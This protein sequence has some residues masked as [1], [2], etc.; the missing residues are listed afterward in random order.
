MTALG[1]LHLH[2]SH[3]YC[4]HCG[5]PGFPADEQIGLSSFLT[6]QACRM[7]TL[8]GI[9]QPFR[10][11]QRVLQELCGWSV[12]AET[13]RQVCH[14][15][16]LRARRH[17]PQRTEA[18]HAFE[19]STDPDREIHID[20]GKVNTPEGW[21]DVKVAVF[22]SRPRGA[23]GN[24]EDYEQ[25]QLP[26]P[27]LCSVVAEVETAQD[28]GLRCAEEARRLG[29][30]ASGSTLSVLGDGAE[31]IWK[32]S[33]EHFEGACEV[34]DVYHGVEKLSEWGREVFGGGTEELGLWLDSARGKLLGDGYWGVCE[35]LV[36]PVEM[37]EQARPSCYE[38]T[39]CV[40]SY[41][42]EHQQRL[43]YAARLVRGQAIGSGL[44]EG[45][46]KQRV[47]LRM[48]RGSARW[49]P[50]HVGPFVELM[51]L[52]DT[53]EWEELWSSMAA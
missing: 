12:C 2:R 15:Q 14:Q 45:T 9:D 49:L 18:P 40:L 21:R 7:V 16:A 37:A 5:Q 52:S 11:A 41:F 47:N 39:A 53:P 10:R 24:L 22:A 46:I 19:Q 26:S 34:L 28:F 44:V 31:W 20:A 35:S 17:R 30:S 51:A 1:P 36:V 43:G 13:I 33:S 27:S 32:L 42:I 29:V 48:K 6:A 25:R 38:K 3:G 8:A 50:Q 4:R 23:P